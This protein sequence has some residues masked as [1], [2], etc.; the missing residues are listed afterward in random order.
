MPRT[1][2]PLLN[3]ARPAHES[4]EN[5]QV[6]NVQP[7]KRSFISFLRHP[8]R[9]PA[10]KDPEAERGPLCFKGRCP[11]SPPRKGCSGKDCKNQI[12]VTY[13]PESYCRS[14]EVWN[15]GACLNQT[16]FLDDCSGPRMAS[17]RQAVILREAEETR[18]SACVTGTTE[19]CANAAAVW[20][21]EMNLYQQLQEAY[22][23]CRQLR[24]SSP[25]VSGEFWF[26]P[27]FRLA[28]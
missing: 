13:Y 6:R 1:G 24:R 12:A 8:F 7:E 9:K 25:A 28:Y 22:Q 18:R 4:S 21:S 3:V 27:Q 16:R 14:G 2:I 20:Q 11:V 5:V 17:E 23:S 10:T 15:G 19:Q 26:A